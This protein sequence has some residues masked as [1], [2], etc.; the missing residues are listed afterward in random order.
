M[1]LSEIFRLEKQDGTLSRSLDHLLCLPSKAIIVRKDHDGKGYHV[2]SSTQKSL[3]YDLS[4]NTTP[5]G[6]DLVCTCTAARYGRLCK[7]VSALM[8]KLDADG[9]LDFLIEMDRTARE[10]MLTDL[11]EKGL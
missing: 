11:H 1:K 4:V 5:Q 2:N 9:Q 3:R 7:H 10:A 6:V 8:L